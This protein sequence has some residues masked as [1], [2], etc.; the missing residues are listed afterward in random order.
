METVAAFAR[1]LSEGPLWVEIWVCFMG[2]VFM[3]AIPF[4]FVRTEARWA[5]AAMTLAFPAMMGLFAV[6]GYV[7]LL[8]LVH[9]VLWTPLAVFLWRRRVDWRIRETL[10][11]KW[12]ALLFATVLVSLA[13]DYV[14]VVRYLLGERS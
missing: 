2:I 4:S 12:L 7:R 6:V 13:F 9:V 5:L 8:G 14:D 1:A 3:M 10:A 11:G